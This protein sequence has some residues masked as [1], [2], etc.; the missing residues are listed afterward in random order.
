METL[1]DVET[2]TVFSRPLVA[3]VGV[4]EW[5]TTG[6]VAFMTRKGVARPPPLL[7]LPTGGIDGIL[8]EG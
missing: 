3:G 8:A 6:F 1:A 4:S 7:L 5:L 2:R